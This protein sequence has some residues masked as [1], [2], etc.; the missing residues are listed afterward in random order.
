M[1]QPL[2]QKTRL[3][4]HMKQ[5]VPVLRLLPACG[6]TLGLAV[7]MDHRRLAVLHHFL[8][9]A[10]LA[11]R[12]PVLLAASGL[13]RVQRQQGGLW[14]LPEVWVRWAKEVVREDGRPKNGEG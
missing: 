3:S 8:A 11:W 10:C 4:P 13:D 9:A 2:H 12:V 6:T 1:L 7:G 5:Q 14:V